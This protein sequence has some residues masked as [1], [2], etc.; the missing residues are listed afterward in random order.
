M[1]VTD[2]KSYLKP[3]MK[4]ELPIKKVELIIIGR[5]LYIPDPIIA[6]TQSKKHIGA[7]AIPGTWDA[8]KWESRVEK[9]CKVCFHPEVQKSSNADIIF[10]YKGTTWPIFL[11]FYW[12]LIEYDGKEFL[13]PHQ[14]LSGVMI[15]DASLV[16]TATLSH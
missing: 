10:P 7:V 4:I 15:K 2:W 14:G 3:L 13:I 11:Y 9:D 1:I 8:A 16:F 5:Q 6:A 12:K